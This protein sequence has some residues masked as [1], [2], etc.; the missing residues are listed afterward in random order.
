MF[1]LHYMET[2]WLARWVVSMGDALIDTN[3]RQEIDDRVKALIAAHPY[4]FSVWFS[5]HLADVVCSLDPE[6]P[7]RGL[8]NDGEV[9]VYANGKRF[10][11]SDDSADLARPA[12]TDLRSDIGLAAL[13]P[14][15]GD[16]AA[17]LIAIAANGRDPVLA[18]CERNIV[19]ASILSEEEANEFFTVTTSALR[20][21]MH[22]RRLYL[23][24]EDPFIHRNGI[25]W[26]GRASRVVSGSP[27]DESRAARQLAESSVPEGT[28]AQLV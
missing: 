21:A 10:G 1:K 4:W 5:G 9:A 18:W 11:T 26:I 25:S 23:G 17:L 20:W 16:D 6:D 3:A 8:K 13:A 7:W 22:R 19:N 12:T 24:P 28:Y 2:K 27:W 15:L 14:G